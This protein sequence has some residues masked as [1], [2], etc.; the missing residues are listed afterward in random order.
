ME[1][2]AT[3]ILN[4]VMLC[5]DMLTVIGIIFLKCYI[6]VFWFFSNFTQGYFGATGAF[7]E[8]IGYKEDLIDTNLSNG[9]L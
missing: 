1:Y 5:Y 3:Q 4:Y 9:T 8:L 6:H 2:S 7:L